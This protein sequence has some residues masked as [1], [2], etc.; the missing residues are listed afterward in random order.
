MAK[1]FAQN[2]GSRAERAVIAILQPIV[3]KV[4]DA[5]GLSRVK[6]QRNALQADGG[7]CDIA[8]LSWIAIEVKHH[9]KL[10]VKQWWEQCVR[11]A[12]E[13]QLPVLI[14]KQNAVKWKVVMFGYVP[15]NELR[16]VRCPVIIDLD[17]FVLWF[18]HKLIDELSKGA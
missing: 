13:D 4:R 3:D 10:Q 8:G 6:L 17:S 9:E 15:I 11:Q 14:Y 18:E 1:S 5:R 2:K 12:K 7:G 16:K